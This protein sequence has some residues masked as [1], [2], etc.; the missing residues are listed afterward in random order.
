MS[1][2]RNKTFTF[3]PEF[4]GM[5]ESVTVMAFLMLFGGCLVFLP[6]IITA[7]RLKPTINTTYTSYTAGFLCLLVALILYIKKRAYINSTKY[8]L[9][10]NKLI[11]ERGFITKVISDIDLEKVIDLEFRQT[12]MQNFFD[13]CTIVI[14]SD[15]ITDSIVKIKGLNA[16]HGK[17]VFKLLQ[18][19]IN[20]NKVFLKDRQYT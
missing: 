4:T 18:Y 1:D 7:G 16:V 8:F 20:S 3:R 13:S 12:I 11:V 19:F 9:T 17:N 10:E 14:Y 6:E 15:D 2:L 5:N